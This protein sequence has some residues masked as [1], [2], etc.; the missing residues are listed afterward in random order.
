MTKF[1]LLSGKNCFMHINAV[2]MLILVLV[3]LIPG[4]LFAA[5]F[6]E[7][8][9][10][11]QGIDLCRA[12]MLLNAQARGVITGNFNPVAQNREEIPI[13]CPKREDLVIRYSDVSSLGGTVEGTKF[14]IMK[15]IADEMVITHYKS[16]ADVKDVVPFRND[17]GIYCLIDRKISFDDSIKNKAEYDSIDN[18]MS[19]LINTKEPK[20]GTYY[21]EYLWGYKKDT[22]DRKEFS[23]VFHDVQNS[24][25]L[26]SVVKNNLNSA[27]LDRLS[28]NIDTSK[29][30][31]TM[32][33]TVKGLEFLSRFD[34]Y[35]MKSAGLGIAAC[36]GGYLLAKAT[37][38]TAAT[39]VG[40]P[41]AIGLGTASA[42]LFATCAV[43]ETISF[44]RMIDADL[45]SIRLTLLVPVDDP[46]LHECT[47][48]YQ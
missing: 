48:I 21:S 7:K 19:F 5:K 24:P 14:N 28:L 47:Q 17:D 26:D 34:S 45:E 4:M 9:S 46:L 38:F 43:S 22:S 29:E 31:Y 12:S 37:G 18:F 3:F 39:G 16:V 6:T 27:D 20:R 1:S 15:T 30:Y 13:N 36:G 33:V 11:K 40:A 35:T 2:A 10:E 41:I 42:I 23:E 25:N 32:H 8:A 44:S